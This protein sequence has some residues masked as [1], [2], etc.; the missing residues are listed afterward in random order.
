MKLTKVEVLRESIKIVVSALTEKSVPVTQAGATAFVEWH[1]VT[2][3]PKRL[4]IPYVP[5]NASDRLI[6]AVQ[7]FVDHECA[8]IL[9]TD[10]QCVKAAIKSGAGM[11]GNILEDTH[12]E[13]KMKKLYAGSRHNLLEVWG[14]I[15][16]EM[17]QGPLDAAI[18]DGS[19]AK[20]VATGLPI[21]IHA[22]AGNEAAEEFMSTR[23]DAFGKIKEI[24][25]DELIDSI[26]KIKSSEDSLNVAVAIKNRLVDWK[27]KEIEE[28]KEKRRKE[29][30]KEKAECDEGADAEGESDSDPDGEPD[31][32]G[33]PLDDPSPIDDE[34]GEATPG[35]DDCPPEELGDG[36]EDE[37]GEVEPGT[38]GDD[39]EED[40]TG[41]P[42]PDEEDSG[43]A[44]DPEFEPTGDEEFESTSH[45]KEDEEFDEEDDDYRPEDETTEDGDA[46]PE[47]ECE[48]PESTSDEDDDGEVA[49]P[50][51]GEL[52]EEEDGDF[53]EGD[54]VS[55]KLSDEEKAMDDPVADEHKEDDEDEHGKGAPEGPPPPSEEKIEDE[56]EEIDMSDFESEADEILDGMEEMDD[57]E[58]NSADL[59]K[60][61]MDKALSTVDYWP[62]TK[63][64]DVIERY[65]PKNTDFEYVRK[66]QEE[67]NVHINHLT[68]RLERLISAKSHN[69]RIPGFRSGKLD[70]AALHRV[71]AGDDRVFRR[72]HKMT[73]KDVDVQLVVDLSGSMTGEK[74]KLATESAYAL[75]TALDRLNI[76][77]QIVGFT[78]TD[79]TDVSHQIEVAKDCD[80]KRTPSRYEP[81]YMPILKDW[82]QRFTADRKSAV[83]MSAR[84]VQLWNNIDGES[85]EYAGRML[86]AQP[87][88]R[89]LMIV[90]SDGSPSA[91]GNRNEQ[92]IHLRRV[93]RRLENEGTEVFGIGI[94]DV[95]VK[96]FYTNCVVI[97]HLEELLSTVMGVL[98]NM[99]MESGR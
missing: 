60:E 23:W 99:L 63:D 85:I 78:T 76:N 57:M 93:V 44:D 73:T 64:C 96:R 68:K 80:D 17:L 53:A 87:G 4:N 12:I 19:K 35:D 88:A 69:R 42:E 32:D 41:E 75:G 2:G 91:H 52:D 1:P 67:I 55:G 58:S 46:E 48:T 54:T 82:G 40:G 95:D 70:G 27:E 31:E 79:M 97:N 89:K 21:A 51:R 72:T 13:R 77:N 66:R 26:P 28:E 6:K 90:L 74:V 25:G 84:D 83:I 43:D 62:L 59:I 18:K 3:R 94:M 81:I 16:D 11:V 33:D 50:E 71:A 37:D 24:I 61:E 47:A 56:E 39:P 30:E 20:I 49:E 7:G 36:E 92:A 5:D 98:E 9:F 15:A 14:F 45:V 86:W 34:D 38:S 8:H 22:W 10:F 65:T 29:R